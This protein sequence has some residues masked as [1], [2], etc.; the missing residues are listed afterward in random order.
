MIDVITGM[1]FIMCCRILDVSFGTVRTLMVVKGH[2]YNAAILG[3]IEVTIWV[4]AIRYI[5]VNLDNM[6]NILGYSL[7]FSLGTILGIT[8]EN[9]FG[10]G[11]VQIYVVSKH[12]TDKIANS[13]RVSKIGVTIL[14]GEGARGGVA[15]LVIIVNVRRRDEVVK[16]IESIDKDAFISIQ[17]AMPYRG[18]IHSRK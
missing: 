2:K 5:M 7:G 15:I 3:F 6:W 13:L 17:T 18:F 1:M 4:I 12:Y 16:I 14:P 11:F 9:K 8:I 10:K